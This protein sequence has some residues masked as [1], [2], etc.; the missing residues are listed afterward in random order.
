MDRKRKCFQESGGFKK[1]RKEYLR[2]FINQ[3]I[4]QD[5]SEQEMVR[6]EIAPSDSEQIIFEQ[7][8]DESSETDA[9]N[10]PDVQEI[11]PLVSEQGD[12]GQTVNRPS[13]IDTQESVRANGISI[14]F[15]IKQFQG[16][17]A[18]WAVTNRVKHDQ[19]RGLL[20]LWNESVPLPN[21][22]ADPRTVLETPRFIT[23][24]NNNYWH[25][26]LE[27]MLLKVLQQ[28]ENVPEKLSLKFNID[29][30]PLSKSSS[31]ECW[32][33]LF[34]VKELPNLSPCIVAVYCGPSMFIYK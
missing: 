7:I 4:R 16:C 8:V 13:E 2:K 21:L 11:A 25:Y 27:K 30:I 23:L 29:G 24:Q 9:Q 19:L 14:D 6:Q 28:I 32:P 17:L 10:D 34:G 31:V 33:I 26:G 18:A 22:P 12:F 20:K 15:D 1:K 3:N 5:C